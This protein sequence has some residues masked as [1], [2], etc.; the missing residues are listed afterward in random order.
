MS[1]AEKI[2]KLFVKSNVTVRAEVDDRI[3]DT[4]LRA[5]EKSKSLVSLSQAKSQ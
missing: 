5:F 1:A 2:K 4:I 3:M